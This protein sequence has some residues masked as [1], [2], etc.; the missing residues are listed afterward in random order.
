MFAQI[1][2]NREAAL[3]WD[4]SEWGRIFYDVVPPQVI[5]T[6]PHSA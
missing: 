6:V 5:K 4:F 3:A 2:R 1:L